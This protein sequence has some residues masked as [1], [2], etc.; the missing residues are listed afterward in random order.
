MNR[1]GPQGN[2]RDKKHSG[3]RAEPHPPTSTGQE[4]SKLWSAALFWFWFTNNSV[5]DFMFLVHFGQCWIDGAIRSA[6]NQLGRKT[7]RLWT[8]DFLPLVWAGHPESQSK[9]ILFGF[10]GAILFVIGVLFCLIFVQSLG[11]PTSCMAA[12][13]SVMSVSSLQQTPAPCASPVPPLKQCNMGAPGS[14]AGAPLPHC[15]AF[16]SPAL[17]VTLGDDCLLRWLSLLVGPIFVDTLAEQK[18]HRKEP[19]LFLSRGKELSKWC[20]FCS[21]YNAAAEQEVC[22]GV[23]LTGTNSRDVRRIWRVSYIPSPLA[24][25]STPSWLFSWTKGSCK[26]EQT[27]GITEK[28]V[29]PVAQTCQLKSKRRAISAY[30]HAEPPGT[31]VHR[32][33]LV[34]VPVPFGWLLAALLYWRRVTKTALITV[35]FSFCLLRLQVAGTFENGN[36]KQFMTLYSLES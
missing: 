11:H 30:K 23:R 8:G 27:F 22:K 18:L 26:K 28:W 31:D 25:K 14:G 33:L 20:G 1:P 13:F 6:H 3:S 24:P 29:F 16:W 17:S 5:T 21:V 4:T 36:P 15:T 32:N 34:L 19:P 12:H 2:R 9:S 35:I 7:L 10:G